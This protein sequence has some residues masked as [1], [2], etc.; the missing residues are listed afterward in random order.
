MVQHR[1]RLEF[2]RGLHGMV[3][4]GIPLNLALAELSN[5]RMRETFG[6]AVA[7]V[8]GAVA[9]GEGLAV[10]M[11]QVPAFF[12]PHTVQLV[13]AA[14]STGTLDGALAHIQEQ[15][16]EN[17]R[18]RWQGVLLCLYPAYLVVVLLF[19]GAALDTAAGA[20]ASGQT[21]SLLAA[22]VGHFARGLL[23]VVGMGAL[24]FIAPLTLAAPPVAV[25]WK[26][27]RR[28]LPLLGGAHRSLEASRFCHALGSSLGAGL[29][30]GRSLELALDASRS[31]G[32]RARARSALL[33]IRGGAALTDVVRW[34]GVLGEASLQQLATGERTG[35]LPEVLARVA[36]DTREAGMR[37][38]RALMIAAIAVL[39]AGLIAPSIGK[40]VQTFERYASQMETLL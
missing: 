29:E 37:R 13:A 5:G 2:F 28:R 22:F 9:A 14:E 18:L 33:R 6:R 21:D 26:R 16:E 36:R 19:G 20:L 1:Q 10:G 38:V 24:A 34:L 7:A 31:L 12:E 40:A 30:A 27:L 11:Q 15:M 35:R 3:R 23:E 17:H 39:V 25:H 4:A 32:L 8:D